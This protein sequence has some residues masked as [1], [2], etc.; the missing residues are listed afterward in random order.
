MSKAA[1]SP[2]DRGEWLTV[3]EAAAEFG[4]NQEYVRQLARDGAIEAQKLGSSLLINHGSLLDYRAGMSGQPSRRGAQARVTEPPPRL[5]T[6][7]PPGPAPA[8]PAPVAPAPAADPLAF[9]GLIDDDA[10]QARNQA[11][12]L[13]L[14]R[15]SAPTAEEANAQRE[16]LTYLVKALD[17]ERPDARKLF[18]GAARAAKKP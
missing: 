13:L 15:L 9:P 11:A 18:P 1:A 10:L 3:R 5:Q 12:I 17:R 7:S 6:I 8:A 14:E 16:T 4:Y 2:F